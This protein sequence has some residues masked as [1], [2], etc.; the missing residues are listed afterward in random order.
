MDFYRLGTVRKP[1]LMERR[2]ALSL[3]PERAAQLERNYL[4]L[5]AREKALSAEVS[6]AARDAYTEMVGFPARVLGN[7]GLIFMADRGIQMTNNIA[8][9]ESR[10]A[11]LRND[12]ETQVENYNTKIAGGKWNRMMPGLVTAKNLTAWNSQVRWPWG[13]PTNRPPVIRPQIAEGNWRD[14]ASADRQ[15]AT[16]PARWVAVAGLGASGRAMTLKPAGLSSSWSAGDDTAP[17]LEYDFDT[18]GGDAEVLID[19]LPTFRLCPGMKLRV[20]VSV[21][22]GAPVPIEVPGSSGADDEKGKSRQNAVQDNYVRATVPLP[23]LASG[24]HMLKIRAVDPG[25]V[26]DRVALP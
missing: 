26:I 12:L 5:L 1:E 21:D 20:A 18:Q 3:T 15:S 22:G 25:V 16:G 10:I 11:Q 19:F 4:D 17:A 9:N 13:E 7:A 14:A 24:K 2:W 6:A 8:A 23:G